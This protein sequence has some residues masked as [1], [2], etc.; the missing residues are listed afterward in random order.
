MGDFFSPGVV[1][2]KKT[3]KLKAPLVDLTLD[4][5]DV[6]NYQEGGEI[7]STIG[8]TDRENDRGGGVGNQGEIFDKPVDDESTAA[9]EADLKNMRENRTWDRV[10][11]GV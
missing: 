2:K 7:V 4:V 5:M 11:A 1:V 10:K 6:G 8:G 9:D 3:P